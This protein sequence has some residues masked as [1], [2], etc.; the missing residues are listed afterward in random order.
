MEKSPADLEEFVWVDNRDFFAN[1]PPEVILNIFSKLAVKDLGQ[2]ALVCRQWWAVSLEPSLWRSLFLEAKR[3]GTIEKPARESVS[4]P[5]DSW[6]DELVDWKERYRTTYHFR[7]GIFMG[8]RKKN[9]ITIRLDS[10]CL[11]AEDPA[12]TLTGEV[13]LIVASKS[14]TTHGIYIEFEAYERRFAPDEENEKKKTLWTLHHSVTDEVA[15][16]ARTSRKLTFMQGTHRFRFRVPFPRSTAPPSITRH[17][18]SIQYSIAYGMRGVIAYP[19]PFLDHWNPIALYPLIVLPSPH[20]RLAL[21]TAAREAPFEETFS[22]LGP[23]LEFTISL[24]K[25]GFFFGE[26]VRMTISVR[27]AM[28]WDYE[29]IT[30]RPIELMRWRGQPKWNSVEPT[31]AELVARHLRQHQQHQQRQLRRLLSPRTLAAAHQPDAADHADPDQQAL[32]DALLQ[33]YVDAEAQ[34]DGDDGVEVVRPEPKPAGGRRSRYAGEQVFRVAVRKN[35]AR[36]FVLEFAVD[37]AHVHPTPWCLPHT[38]ELEHRYALKVKLRKQGLWAASTTE[39]A[40]T[41]SIVFDTPRLLL[42]HQHQT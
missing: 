9:E 3:A 39:K 26:K 4:A 34:A 20:T 40:M 1:Q 27:N 15:W 8:D 38:V 16:E 28:P 42:H 33:S 24:P 2:A 10:A 7:K 17:I 18:Q 19:W 35:S 30:V 5:D 12:L 22:R 13:T 14:I 37:E 6:E 31:K 29:Q 41:G 21:M 36:R 32:V 25:S 23:G 11:V